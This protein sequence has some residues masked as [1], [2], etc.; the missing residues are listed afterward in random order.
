MPISLLPGPSQLPLETN[1]LLFSDVHL[2]ADLV[3]HARPWTASR[4]R[5]ELRIDRELSA[6]LDHYRQRRH[7]DQP[8]RLII[9]GDLVDF[10]GMSIAAAHDQ[11][12]E[13][14]LTAEERSHGLGSTRDHVV[15]KMRAVAA[16]HDLV[17]RK[18]AEF[19]AEGHSLVLV[20]GNHDVDFY[21]PT[22]RE[23]FVQAL[24]ERAPGSL[25][26]PIVRQMFESR[27]EFRHW[28][29]YVEG[30][31]YV[32]HG[33]Q[34]DETCS[35]HN[36]L[37]PLSPRDPRRIAFSFS[38]IL[39]RYVV[40]PTK[41]LGTS[42]HDDM[43]LF[44]YVRMAF[45]MGIAGAAK[46]GYR[47]GRAVGA[48]LRS[49]REHLSVHAQAMRAE[50]EQKLHVLGERLRLGTDK[51]RALTD[52]WAKPV[53]SGFFPILR[54]V[55]LDLAS[56][57]AA[58]ALLVVGLLATNVVP[59]TYVAPLAA[60]LGV[61]IYAWMKASR[62]LD[63]VGALRKGADRVATLMPARFIVMGHTHVPVMETIVEGVTYINL[64]GWAVDDLDKVGVVEAASC[65]HLVIRHMDGVPHAELRAWGT[66]GP[67]LVHTSGVLP[68][69]G[70]HAIPISGD[71]PRVDA[72][73][74]ETDADIRVA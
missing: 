28:F 52:L 7:D 41:G 56:A 32:E 60:A 53:T 11:P 54:T 42:G 19:V 57:I 48:M 3:Q 6:M 68:E 15:Y 72:T 31:L 14:P 17:F 30:L 33:H 71:E 20:R 43:K 61:G 5:E 74:L 46:L 27:I 26:E 58:S 1:Y 59:A 13:T 16:R 35:Y 10:M 40:H 70:V 36:V 66:D 67:S 9:A 25:E 49:W 24:V 29:Y 39:M 22:A 45:A 44:D 69:S 37:M 55:F 34:Y 21:W 47:F 8:W 2:G 62:V 51:L 50:Q 12:V 73:D 65:T 64:G 63:P 18:L 4:L 38:D 23:A